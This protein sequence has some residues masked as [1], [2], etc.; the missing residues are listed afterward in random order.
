MITARYL[1]SVLTVTVLTS[2]VLS[3]SLLVNFTEGSKSNPFQ[4][5]PSQS[6]QSSSVTTAAAPCGKLPISSIKAS[7]TQSG[8]S[9][10]NVADGD[11]NARWSN[12]GLNS[13]VQLDLGKQMTICSIDIAWYRGNVRVN[14]FVISGSNDGVNFFKIFSGKSSGLTTDFE[15]YDLKS[16]KAKVIRITI[17]LNSQNNWASISEVR[18]FGK[19]NEAPS[20]SPQPQPTGQCNKELKANGVSESGGQP[21][22]GSLDASFAIDGST[23]SRWSSLGLGSSITLKLDKT[24]TICG[25]NI[26][27]Y[28]GTERTNT[29]VISLSNNGKSFT[30]VFEGSSKRQSSFESYS[31]RDT[32]AQFL[33]ITVTGNS[34]NNWASVSEVKVFGRTDTT[35]SPSP[36]PSPGP[37]PSPSPSPGSNFKFAA[38]GDWGCDS[39]ATATIANMQDKE[40]ELILA[41]G[42]LSYQSSP[43]CWLD[44][45]QDIEGITRI[46]IGNHDSS[47]KESS[48]LEKQYLQHFNL[49]QPFY[50]FDYKNAHFLILSSQLKAGKGDA[51]YEFVDND[52]DKVSQNKNIKWIIVAL[53]K[54][55]YTSPTKHSAE[56]DFRDIYHPLFD[57]Y[58]V[59]LVLQAHNHNYQRSF[60]ISYNDQKSASPKITDNENTEYNDPKGAIYVVAGTGG[61]SLYDL[62]SK[63]PFIVSQAEEYGAFEGRITDGGSKLIGTFFTNDR[64][65]IIDKFTI[66]K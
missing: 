32:S 53:H 17:T 15:K 1:N 20:P 18:V 61:K 28:R 41:L 58:G 49:A 45:I 11:L 52:L 57:K 46:I 40:P 43:D 62:K 27:W 14:D 13:W 19:P 16:A 29:F 31:F 6:F 59:D 51:Q 56:A 34:Q 64:N 2:L 65:E 4:T 9:P 12:F 54:P 25:V 38:A 42:D 36:S 8:L 7:G 55:L 33:R 50:S 5:L 23:D 24:S 21:A 26:S 66:S 48:A 63:A 22:A 10:S 39:K 30:D 3:S 37:S 35:P 60:P 44:T 47:E